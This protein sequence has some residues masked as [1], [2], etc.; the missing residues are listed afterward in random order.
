[1]FPPFP[2]YLQRQIKELKTKQEFWENNYKT[3][4]LDGLATGDNAQAQEIVE[5]EDD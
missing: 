3:L 2:D 5:D 4:N 1:M